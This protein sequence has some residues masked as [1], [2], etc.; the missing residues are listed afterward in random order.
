MAHHRRVTRD[1]FI[2]RIDA[3]AAAWTAGD[4]PSAAA[5]F[6]E[7]VDY[8]DPLRYRFST[9]DEL[10]PFFEPPPDG[11]RVVIH[12][13]LFDLDRQAG[14]VEY[15]YVGDHRYHGAAIVS[16]DRDGLIDAWRE[17]QHVDDERDWDAFLDQPG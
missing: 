3:L 6:A 16:V 8:R 15:T 11:H 12:G 17:W 1:A 7:R 5:H 9:R 2:A 14:V 4:A 13:V 10:L